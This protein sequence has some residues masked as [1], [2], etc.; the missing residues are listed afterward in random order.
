MNVR[1]PTILL[2]LLAI[3]VSIGSCRE[4]AAAIDALD[5]GNQGN[6]GDGS[7]N[8]T[9]GAPDNGDNS[10]DGDTGG[11]PVVRL[12]ASNVSPQT[13]E[14]VVLNCDLISGSTQN[15]VFDFRPRSSRLIADVRSGRAIFVVDQTDI[16]IAQTFTC[17]AS[18]VNGNGNAS[19][20]VTFIPTEPATLP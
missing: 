11:V 19:N 6:N 9:G 14:E 5:Q 2:L 16:G 7:G 8:G 4:I 1:R 15:L 10:P 3:P 13:G 18:N 17:S 12:M 20:L